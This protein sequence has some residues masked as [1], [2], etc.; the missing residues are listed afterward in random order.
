MKNRRS[1]R[2]SRQ[3]AAVA[4]N[5]ML[6]PLVVAMRLPLLAGA[7]RNANPWGGETALAFAEKTSAVAEGMVAAQMS[8]LQSAWQF[9][10]ELL[11]GRMPSVLNGMAA[12]R[13]MTAALHP[14]SRAVMAN[15]RRL[16]AR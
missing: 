7:S 15:F 9:W 1:S 2:A 5:L 11:S 13:S 6:A 16:S 4:A 8:C 14:A 3:S 10:P 12:E